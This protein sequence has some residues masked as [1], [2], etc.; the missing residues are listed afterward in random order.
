MPDLV[1]RTFQSLERVEQLQDDGV[2]VSDWEHVA[3]GTENA[4]ARIVEVMREHGIDTGGRPP[5]WAWRG[6][7]RLRDADSLFD[8]VHELSRGY[9]TVTFRAPK[10]L[11]LLSDYAH[12]CDVLMAPAGTPAHQWQPQRRAEGSHQPE[13]AC[14]PYLR[15]DWVTDI[16]SLPTSGWDTL[17]LE[18][19]L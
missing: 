16:K 15:L 14:L 9:A 11:V 1:L 4:Y 13:Q 3:L 10:H 17:D 8:A 19:P 12:W 2:L 7:V 18:T 6:L 5:V